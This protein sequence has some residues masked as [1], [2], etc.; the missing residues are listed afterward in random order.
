MRAALVIMAEAEE[1]GTRRLECSPA[2]IATFGFSAA[3]CHRNPGR[4]SIP[5]RDDTQASR[6]SAKPADFPRDWTGARLPYEDA[7]V[8]GDR[9]ILAKNFERQ[10]VWA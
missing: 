4:V 10:E 9:H 3:C 7:A 5:S 8:V 6:P 1:R 2:G